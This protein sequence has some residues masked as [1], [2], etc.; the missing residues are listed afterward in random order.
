MI[1]TR[2]NGQTL[3][4]TLMGLFVVTIG[5]VSSVTLFVASTKAS[6]DTED[7]MVASN[8][9][10]EGIEAVRSI[11]DDNWLFMESTPS[12]T[13][14][15]DNGLLKNGN[16]EL[17]VPVFDPTTRKWHLDFTPKDFDDKCNNGLFVCAD[18][19]QDANGLYRQFGNNDTPS[20]ERV[21]FQRLITTQDIC[22]DGDDDIDILTNGKCPSGRGAGNFDDR[23]IGLKLIVTVKWRDG[24]IE[25][26]YV[27]EEQIYQWKEI[28]L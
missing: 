9:A 28:R 26:N 1:Q 27:L 6:G 4:E 20:E 8:L 5:V 23:R 3:I 18:V 13:F 15:W 2:H 16:D 22:K 19:Y 11:R 21:K 10:R 25:K 12:L 7:Q 14:F 17:A 24:E